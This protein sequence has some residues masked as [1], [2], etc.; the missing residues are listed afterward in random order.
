MNPVVLP[1]FDNSKIRDDYIVSTSLSIFFHYSFDALHTYVVLVD[2]IPNS[3][4]YNPEFISSNRGSFTVV[5]PHNFV[6]RA[7]TYG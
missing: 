3:H 1:Y 4:F 2:S 5:S 7:F 6:L